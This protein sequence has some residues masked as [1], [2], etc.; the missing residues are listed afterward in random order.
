VARGRCPAD[1]RLEAWARDGVVVPE[2]EG[3]N[4]RWT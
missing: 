1:D 3:G 4:G 2:P